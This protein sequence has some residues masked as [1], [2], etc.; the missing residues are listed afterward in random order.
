M[1]I[2]AASGCAALAHQLLWTRR[3]IDLLGGSSESTTRVFGVFFLGLAVGSALS[4]RWV[5]K[6]RRPLRA[7]AF[8]EIAVA[9]LC[10]PILVLP[11]WTDWIWPTIGSDGLMSWPGAIVKL[12]ISVVVIFPPSLMMGLFLPFLVRSFLRGDSTIQRQ[13]LWLYA[14]NTFGGVAGMFLTVG[15]ALH[16]F[17][18]WGSMVFAM[19]LNLAVAGGCLLLDRM[20]GEMPVSPEAIPP[21]G[22]QPERPNLSMMLIAFLSGAGILAVEVI[23]LELFLLVASISFYAVSAIVATAILMLALAALLAERL[24]KRMAHPNKLIPISMSLGA[25]A[26]TGA[27]VLYFFLFRQ[28]HFSGAEPS[29]LV[30]VLKLVGA[31]AFVFGAAL[32]LLGLTFPLVVAWAGSSGHDPDGTRL[33]WL[34]ASNGVGGLIGAELAHRVVLPALNVHMGL[35]LVAIFYGVT[36]V[37]FACFLRGSGVTSSRVISMVSL[38][39]VGLV[40]LFTLPRYPVLNLPS[41]A[42]IVETNVGREGIVSV[43]RYPGAGRV[44]L[45]R[46]QYR[47]GGELSR[48]VQERQGHVPLLL[49]ENPRRVAFVGAA[50]GITPSSALQHH[51]V[52]SIVAI[53]LSPLV[54][55]AAQTHF[56]DLNGG[57]MED[58]RTKIVI[59]DG[60]TFLA[61]SP[62]QF[63]VVIAD[64]FLPWNPGVG[65]LYSL[66][67]FRSTRAALRPGG[68]FCQWLPMH[69]LSPEHFQLVVSTFQ[70]VFGKVY[71]F[72]NG[73]AASS[74]AVALV[75]FRDGDLDWKIAFQ[76]CGEKRATG[77][78]LD[79]L[80]RHGEGLMMLYLGTYHSE[81]SA[82]R[83]N[84]LDNMSFE[85]RVGD[86]QITAGS[87]EFYIK[88]NS[89]IDFVAQSMKQTKL[90]GEYSKLPEVGLI[91]TLLD[92][93]DP[94]HPV[95]ASS[96]R[97][98]RANFPSTIA[99]DYEADWR[100]WPDGQ[101]WRAN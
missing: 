50:T 52:E 85:L 36:G 40:V 96:S 55:D 25:L 88:G 43:V 51:Q 34:L 62:N 74:T 81:E 68:I 86:D 4:V 82:I 64:M 87:D 73:T 19:T 31:V 27:P 20:H 93:T 10:L 56:K 84:T 47:L 98:L 42:K 80:V 101:P 78:L 89:W 16:A 15:Y 21:E 39:V 100:R 53:E 92:H 97:Y 83:A 22:V 33:G 65:R 75:G 59:E 44:I 41:G 76:Q 90:E 79:P 70:L 18:A 14:L 2:S 58:S 30:F 57:I 37:L 35:G 12:L 60:R 67:H 54:V 61:A 46:N 28:F 17:G 23:S 11:W 48:Y 95:A 24:A 77:S 99:T 71:M 66:E 9:V 72:R 32:L 38:C 7:T 8:F 3:L 29:T 91:M 45:V 5:G 49:H 13:G 69:Q 1:A 63:D 6:S 94:S 26:L